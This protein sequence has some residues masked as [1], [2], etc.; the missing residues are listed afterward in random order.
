VLDP[1]HLVNVGGF[2]AVEALASL[3]AVAATYDDAQLLSVLD[4]A[5]HLA[6]IDKSDL[7]QLRTRLPARRSVI[8][9]A[10]GRRESPL[11]SRTALMMAGDAIRDVEPQVPIFVLGFG[12]VRV[13]FQLGRTV[14]VEADGA[15]AHDEITT[16]YADRKRHE[17]LERLGYIIVRVTWADVVFAPREP[18]RASDPP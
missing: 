4:S 15:E 9:F 17:A 3:S 6:K 8:R 2:C 12:N 11:G 18:S 14:I 10:D 7:Q 16:R 1:A 13:D 5:L